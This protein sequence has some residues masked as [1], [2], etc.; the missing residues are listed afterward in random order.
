MNMVRTYA[1]PA[2]ESRWGETEIDFNWVEYAPPAPPM[3]ATDP[4]PANAYVLLQVPQGWDGGMHN[5]PMRQIAV[6]LSG[7]VQIETSDGEAKEFGAGG[8]FAMEDTTGVGHTARNIGE[9]ELT[10]IM[11]HLP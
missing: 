6:V 10:V 8:I 5:T 7:K 3:G 1:D 2:G 11:I 4:L 9:G